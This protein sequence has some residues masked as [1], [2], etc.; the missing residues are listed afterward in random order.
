MS[1]DSVTKATR[2]FYVDHSSIITRLENGK[3][4]DGWMFSKA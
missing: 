3:D 4:L 1:F 2:F